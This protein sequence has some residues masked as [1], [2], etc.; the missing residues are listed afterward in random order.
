MHE[1]SVDVRVDLGE[2]CRPERMDE[3]ELGQTVLQQTAVWR[4]KRHGG[5][6]PFGLHPDVNLVFV[7]KAANDLSILIVPRG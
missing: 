7:G 4:V 2:F 6:R 3:V 5:I 1:R